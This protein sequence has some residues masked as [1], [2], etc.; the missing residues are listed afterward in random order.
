MTRD[1]LS[2]QVRH[3]D[4]YVSEETNAVRSAVGQ[5]EKLAERIVK[6]KWG[7][8]QDLEKMDLWDT[9]Y[10]LWW[11]FPHYLAAMDRGKISMGLPDS[12]IDNPAIG[13]SL[14]VSNS[15]IPAKALFKSLLMDSRLGKGQKK[16]EGLWWMRRQEKNLENG[17]S[18]KV[19]TDW[20]EWEGCGV[21]SEGSEVRKGDFP[22]W[23][24]GH[25][26]VLSAEHTSNYLW[27]SYFLDPCYL[28]EKL[29]ALSFSMESL[30]FN[31]LL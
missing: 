24:L 11:F 16:P 15:R 27:L 2:L 25:E 7:P 1:E 17:D 12:L 30:S 31:F 29:V 21:R 26:I 19:R 9:I 18:V 10:V 4:S 23:G 8:R 28:E 20:Q 5:Q 6:K 22:A 14:G 3:S 13:G